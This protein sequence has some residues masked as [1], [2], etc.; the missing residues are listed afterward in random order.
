ME[1]SK[2]TTTCSGHI[3]SSTKN[4]QKKK[5]KTHYDRKFVVQ[6]HIKSV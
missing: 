6:K 5:K 2:G 3:S 4:E 1:G